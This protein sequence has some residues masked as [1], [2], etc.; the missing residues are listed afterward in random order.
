MKRSYALFLGLLLILSCN[1]EVKKEIR[2]SENLSLVGTWA[3]VSGQTIIKNDTIFADYTKGKKMIKIINA[4]HFAFLRHDL[5]HGK[6]STTADYAA[7]GGTYTLVGDEYTENLE[8]FNDRNWEGHTFHFK[9]R[10]SND[11]LIQTGIEKLD[12]LGIDQKIIERYVKVV[13]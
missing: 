11:T 1:V 3:L 13:N 8:Y 6:D 2:D 10:V 5:N 7:G 12:S 9:V 4:T